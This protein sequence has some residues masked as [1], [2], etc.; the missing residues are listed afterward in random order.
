MKGVI[1]MTE[2]IKWTKSYIEDLN[3]RLKAVGMPT[4]VIRDGFVY[5]D[6]IHALLGIGVKLEEEGL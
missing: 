3:E 2:D 1:F 6:E 5:K 4:L